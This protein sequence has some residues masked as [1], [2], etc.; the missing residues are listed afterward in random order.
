MSRVAALGLLCCEAVRGNLIAS[1]AHST[2]GVR[3]LSA[4]TYQPPRNL[5]IQLS[6]LASRIAG[7]IIMTVGETLPFIDEVIE[8]EAS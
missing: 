8:P 4:W 1:A 2:G 7:V 5:G 6:K 3:T